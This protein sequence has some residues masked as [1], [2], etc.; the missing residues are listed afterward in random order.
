MCNAEFPQLQ[1]LYEKYRGQGFAMV[2][3]NVVPEEAKDIPDWRRKGGYSFPV[4]L[5]DGDFAQR[6]YD[7]TAEPT[8]LLLDSGHRAV[9]RHLGYGSGGERQMEAEIREL[10][11]L[12]P[13][14]GA[15]K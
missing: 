11:G 7:V 14:E 6:T 12:D 13:F 2:A 3:I 15:D 9:F 8:N 1:K 4:L 5:S 10:L